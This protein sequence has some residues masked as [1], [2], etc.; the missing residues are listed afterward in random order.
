MSESG[1]CIHFCIESVRT[2]LFTLIW[3]KAPFYTVVFVLF[4]VHLISLCSVSAYFVFLRVFA[5]F[6]ESN[7]DEVTMKKK[8]NCWEKIFIEK[9]REKKKETIFFPFGFCVWYNISLWKI[10]DRFFNTS[11][12]HCSRFKTEILRWKEEKKARII[13]KWNKKDRNNTLTKS[14]YGRKIWMSSF[15]EHHIFCCCCYCWCCCWYS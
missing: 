15:F 12:Y 3:E 8:R 13:V 5:K 11:I 2:K 1:W 7:A 6:T 4:G 14:Q 9:R 10:T